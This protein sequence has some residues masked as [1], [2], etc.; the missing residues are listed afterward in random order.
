MGKG[1][2]EIPQRFAVSAGLL[3]VETQVAGVAEHL[4]EHEAGL[5]QSL[6]VIPAGPR[7]RLDEPEGTD[8]EGPLL[9]IQ[10]VGGLVHVVAI[11][12]AVGDQPA[13]FGRLVH[14]VQGAEHPGIRGGEKKHQRHHEVGGIERRAAVMLDK[15]P[16]VAIP[17]LHHDLFI[18]RVPNLE[19]P[20]PVGGE[21][22][23]VGQ[24]EAPV[25]RYPTHELGVHEVLPASADFP[26][27][28]ILAL[29]MRAHPVDELA[30]MHP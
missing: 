28:F 24:P 17:P 5:L 9:P 19:P 14:G 29:P 18:N 3:P 23:L 12:E 13:G 15:G 22:P 4:F 8:V 10:S 25:D 26:N 27:A 1:L 7:Q 20:L 16:Q 2:R 30:E 6:A 11:D 21:R